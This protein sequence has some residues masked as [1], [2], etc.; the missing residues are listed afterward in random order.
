MTKTLRFLL[1]AIVSMVCDNAFA[2]ES[3]EATWLA[4]SHDALSTVL[5]GND[6]KLVWAEGGGDLAPK[7]SDDYVYFYNGNRV[8]VA[9]TDAAVKISKVVFKFKTDTKTGIAT[10]DASGKNVSTTGITNDNNALTSTWEGT[11][12]NSIIFRAT[13]GTGAR[14]IE[15]ITITYEGSAP[16]VEKAPVL[17]VTTTLG[18]T[19]DMDTAPVFVVYA[20]NNGNAAAN[21][22]KLTVFVDGT[23]NASWEIGTIAIE[24]QKWQNM[25]F[26][27]E[28]LAAGEHQVKLA[29]TADGAEE[30]VVEKTVTF[31][32]AAPVP[33]FTISAAAVTVPYTAESYS[34]VATLTETNN[35]AAENVKVELRK[36]ISDVLATQ[37]VA[38]LAA[39]AT[40]QVTLTVAKDLFET[41]E[42]TYNLYV[43]DK[44]LAN[45]TVTF[46][47]APVVN[48]VDLAVTGIQGSIDQ[49]QEANNI[50]VLVENKGNVDIE[51]ANITLK[52]GDTVLGTG[53]LFATVR[54]GESNTGFAQI[55]I[56]TEVRDALEATDALAVT[57]TAEVE[58]ED[59]DKLDNN[60]FS[61]TIVVKAVPVP[62]ATYS[63]AAENVTVAYGAESFAI[64][65]TVKNTS[66]VE[67]KNVVVKLTQNAQNIVDPVTIETLA[68]GAEQE[69]TFTVAGPF[70]AGTT[71]RYYVQVGDEFLAN[72]AQQEV[73]VTF[74]AQAVTPVYDLAIDY[75][76]GSIDLAYE[77]A[78]ISVAVKNNGNQDITDAAVKLT[79]GTTDYENTV[80]VTAG[81][82]AYAIFTV[83]TE[84]LTAGIISV[85]ASVTVENDAT[86]DNTK[87]QEIEV[88]AA[89]VPEATF[90]VTA[91]NVTVAYG[92]E[93]FEIKAVVKNTSEVNAT[94]VEVRLLNGITEV[95]TTT[96]SEL[97]AGAEQ[98]VVFQIE[99]TAEAPFVAGTTA[100]YYVQAAGKEQ[101]EV[102]VTF[103]P[104]SVPEVKDLAVTSITGTIDLNPEIDDFVSVQVMNNG[105]VDITDANVT[106]K[107]NNTVVG[108][109][110]VSANAGETGFKTIYIDITTLTLQAGN[111]DVTVEVEVEGDAT[112]DDNTMTA[113]LT[114]KDTTTG[115][116]AIKA[117]YGENVQI[118]T[119]SGRRV[120]NVVKGQLYIINGKTVM[121]K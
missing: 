31:T 63:V 19:Y 85:T 56:S 34:V 95:A 103:E 37:T 12:V 106:I 78:N 96:I 61:G 25:K 91:D 3:N 111:I 44:F 30:A 45:V 11:A 80:S 108:T 116:A 8:T 102:T 21:N 89:P 117:Q 105:T 4:S 107:I 55:A 50:T 77:S 20:N 119:L 35:V 9:G 2:Q 14:Y 84:G 121:V 112:P 46:E 48:V 6:L 62:Q 32:K 113:T 17:A 101:A 15:S 57:A 83:A 74:E 115:I 33:A 69:V 94:D 60:T 72:K 22:A 86:D 40:E 59:A 43:N 47:A 66:E 109:G 118:Y 81:E 52:A 58:G 49:A 7:Y 5:V 104:E 100:T 110:T 92:A 67:A 97:N 1:L 114:V 26:N 75:I 42:K 79:V 70:T 68:A 82:T 39:G 24:E 120:N 27:L 64:K 10:C 51:T 90:S 36:G 18:D 29:L 13:Q 73:T 76:Q 88:K 28:G 87:T 99:P 53:S 23:E 16:I 54:A 38:T 41:G 65:A 98:P 71:A 93:Y